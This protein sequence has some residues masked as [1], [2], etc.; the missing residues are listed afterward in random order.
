MTIASTCSAESAEP[1]PSC[2]E[3]CGEG[4]HLKRHKKNPLHSCR[5]RETCGGADEP[6]TPPYAAQLRNVM[7]EPW[8]EEF[9]RYWYNPRRRENIEAFIQRVAQFAVDEVRR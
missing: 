4:Q 3:H 9:R 5:H 2:A 7:S 8:V 1:C 6:V